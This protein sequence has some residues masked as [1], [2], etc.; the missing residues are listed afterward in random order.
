MIVL[1]YGM[2]YSDS[3]KVLHRKGTKDYFRKAYIIEGDSVDNYEEVDDYPSEELEQVREAKIAEIDAYDK[4]KNVNWFYV[5]G[6]GMWYDAPKRTTIRNLVESSIKE[7]RETTTLWTEEEP[8][9]PLEVPCEMALVLLA[10]L[11]V[12]AGDC[13]ANTQKHKSEIMAMQSISEI[14]AYDFT[15]GYPEM[16]NLSTEL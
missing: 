12:Y 16:L 7:G 14:E 4:S 2:I 5:N 9:I 1:K 11:E 10:K 13:L 6:V 8:I 3:D 15:V